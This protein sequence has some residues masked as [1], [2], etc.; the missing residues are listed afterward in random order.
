MLE[1]PLVGPGIER[2]VLFPNRTNV[3]WYRELEPGRIRARIFERGVGETM[4]SG[5]G[6][7]GAAVAYHL[8]GGPRT[9]KVELDPRAH[10]GQ[11]QHLE[12]L[13]SDRALRI[14]DRDV[15]K[16]PGA[17]ADVELAAAIRSS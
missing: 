13:A 2:H 12:L 4:S 11:L 9:V 15:L 5:T 10:Q 6:A 16:A 8:A 1:L 7:C 17:T 14:A 3:S